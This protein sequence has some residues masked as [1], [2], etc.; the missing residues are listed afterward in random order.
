VTRV[1]LSPLIT[2]TVSAASYLVSSVLPSVQPGALWFKTTTSTSDP[3]A[4]VS[5]AA[6]SGQYLALLPWK[7]TT[8][9]T[10][11]PWQQNPQSQ[12][13]LAPVTQ[14]FDPDGLPGGTSLQQG[15]P[16]ET[17]GIQ[18]N[19]V[20]QAS[21]T[22]ANTFNIG[23]AAGNSPS[24]PTEYSAGLQN[25]VRFL[26]NW[27]MGSGAQSAGTTTSNI[28]GSFIQFKRSSYAT[29]PYA[30]I[31]TAT[32]TTAP[33]STTP[34]MSLFVTPLNNSSNKNNYYTNQGTT[35][36]TPYYVPPNRNWGFDVALLSQLPDLFA[37]QFTVPPSSPPTEYF[38]EVNSDDTWLQALLCAKQYGTGNNAVTAQYR[39]T[40]CPTTTYP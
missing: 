23:F 9:T 35:G 15:T 31:I 32:S 10:T 38:R 30:Q 7:T 34:S 12:P 33:S 6:G 36:T 17:P 19:W 16:G 1:S 27:Y 28:S 3:T 40:T 37:Q 25:F 11:P 13:Q 39:P 4:S 24:R 2:I 22:S 14:I 5:Y 26:E 21:T 18:Q 29:A 20:Q 8:N